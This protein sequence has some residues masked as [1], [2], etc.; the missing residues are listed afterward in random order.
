MATY[1]EWTIKADGV[2]SLCWT[3]DSLVDWVG[4][5]DM[6]HLDDTVEKSYVRFGYRFDLAAVSPSGNY[7]AIYERLGT[8][9]LIL[10]QGNHVREINRSYYHADVYEYPLHFFR[11]PSGQEVIAHCPNAYN[12]IEIEDI[13][14]GKSL[15]SASERNPA[16]IF[17]SRLQ[18]SPSGKYLLSAGWVW[19]PWG[20]VAVYDVEEALEHPEILDGEGQ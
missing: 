11:L 1:K 19:Q 6:Y 13:E 9:G 18:T 5:G 3:G 17:H 15:L 10:H 4:G 14:S 12:Q 20:I 7:A 8:K 16:D 2:Q